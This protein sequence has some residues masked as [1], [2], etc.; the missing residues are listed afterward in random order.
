MKTY[1]TLKLLAVALVI[2]IAGLTQLQAQ[3]IAVIHPTEGNHVQGIVRFTQVKDG[4]HVVAD[5]SGL[6][7][8]KH[9]FH[10]H[11]YG[12]CSD[13]R[14]KSA[15]G[16]FNPEGTPHGAPTDVSSMRH[17]GDLGNIAA[18]E[19]GNA[20]L[21]WIDPLLSLSGSHNIIG[22]SVV[23][24]GGADDLKSQP[25]GAAGPRVAFGVI[26]FANPK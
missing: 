13:P 21:D 22:R 19:N 5:L 12:D 17:V 1:Q 16:H 14:G 3:A 10:I 7:P 9:G 4:V 11:A 2:T 6:T 8:G 26:G 18:D 23:V 20:H 24:H 25:S 15:G